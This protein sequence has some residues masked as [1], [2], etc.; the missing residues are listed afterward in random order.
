MN[1][2]QLLEYSRDLLS[3]LKQSIGDFLPHIVGAIVIILVGHFV[4]RLFSALITRLLK[5]LSQLIPDPKAQV[6]LKPPKIVR[7]ADLIGK[8]IY[9]IVLFFFITVATEMIGLPIVTT[10]LGGIAGYLPKIIIAS[11]ILVSGMIGG[12]LLRDIITATAVSANITYGNILGKLTQYAI[13]IISV[14]IAI[15]H[16]GIEIS[17]LTSLVLIICGAVFF[18][19]ALAFGLGARPFVNDI[20]ASYYLQKT[21]KVGQTVKIGEMKGKIMQITPVAVIIETSDGHVYTPAKMFDEMTSLLS[22]EEK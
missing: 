15:D 9:W 8:I 6:R 7:S 4:A 14:S 3:R 13:V 1:Y 10:W 12:M 17:F 18:G 2:R 20:L 19:S 11:L 16:L 22:R 21:Y 5:K